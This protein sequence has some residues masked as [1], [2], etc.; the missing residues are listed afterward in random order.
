MLLRQHGCIDPA[1]VR[2]AKVRVSARNA[3]E[4]AQIRIST[5][6]N[7]S[8]LIVLELGCAVNVMVRVSLQ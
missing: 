8:A 2:G 7:Q 6:Q 4:R 5:Q 1:R 3:M